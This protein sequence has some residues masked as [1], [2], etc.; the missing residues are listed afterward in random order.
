MKGNYYTL[1]KI[2]S[3]IIYAVGLMA[4]VALTSQPTFAD[5]IYTNLGPGNSYGFW[6]GG[7][8]LNGLDEGGEVV[9]NQFTVGTEA[10]VWDAQLALTRFSDSNDPLDVYIESDVLGLPGVILD[11]LSQVGVLPTG[12]MGGLVPFLCTGPGCTLAGGTYWLVAWNPN[13]DG[14]G[15][16][17]FTYDDANGPV[18][19]NYEDN[20]AGPWDFSGNTYANA[21]QVETPEP[22]SLLLLGSGLVLGGMA[23][24]RKRRA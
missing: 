21:F 2:R 18:A 8:Q 5:I 11:T 12:P 14:L 17:Y 9:A 10:T 20:A 3:V 24:R 22:G 15:G 19:A 6:V 13:T 23:L 7:W 1:A 4:A 16:W